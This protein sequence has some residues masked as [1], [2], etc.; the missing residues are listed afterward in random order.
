LFGQPGSGKSQVTMIMRGLLPE[1]SVS[2]VP[3]QDWGDRFLPTQM[4]GKVLNFA[5]ELSETKAIPGEIFKQ[6]IEGEQISGQYKNQDIFRFNPTCA[7]WF[8]SNH[9]PKTRDSSDG[10]NR[11]WLIFEW[12]KRVDPAKR[13]PDLASIILEHETEAIVAWAVE[14]FVRLRRNRD[15]TLPSSHLACVDQMATDNNSVRYFLTTSPRILVGAHKTDKE[16]TAVTLHGEYWSFCIGVGTAQR[17]SL[18]RF[19]AMMKELQPVFGF[20]EVVQNST[21]SYRHVS[22]AGK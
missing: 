14:G 13:I 7:Q 21:V 8:S 2:S 9:L 12:N 10:F 3:P 20:Q 11:R 5:G 22:L 19:I 16:I 4:F 17:V 18:Q 15:Y 6:V 1:D